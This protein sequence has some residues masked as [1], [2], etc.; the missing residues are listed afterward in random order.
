VILTAVIRDVFRLTAPG[1]RLLFV[2]PRAR[3]GAGPGVNVT[4]L[5]AGALSASGAIAGLALLLYR[6]MRG[7]ADPSSALASLLTAF[8]A[9]FLGSTTIIPGGST[10]RA[11]WW[12]YSSRPPGSWG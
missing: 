9:A 1:R 11:R 2:G 6:G 4:Q 8:A 7:S 12:R 10:R 5:R 3:G